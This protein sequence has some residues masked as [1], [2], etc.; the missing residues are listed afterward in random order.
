[1]SPLRTQPL[2]MSHLQER[3]DFNV[4]RTSTGHPNT[5]VRSSGIRA[6]DPGRQS[7]R[8]GRDGD[9]FRPRLSQRAAFLPRKKLHWPGRRAE[10]LELLFFD[11]AGFPGRYPKL[12]GK[13]RH[14]V[15]R[16][17]L[18][19]NADRWKEAGDAWCDDLR[20]SRG[21]DRLVQVVYPDGT[22]AR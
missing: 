7:P 14:R 3:E 9:M 6:H 1:D 20:Y 12:R 22:G 2:E 8:P 15:G 4:R 5:I 11:D 16:S 19:R 18:S 17:A 10:K 13:G 21:A